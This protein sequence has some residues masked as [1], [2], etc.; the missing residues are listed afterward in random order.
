[1]A[2]LFSE[3]RLFSCSATDANVFRIH[4][5]EENVLPVVSAQECKYNDRA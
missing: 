2:S 5:Q 4:I 3:L 1:M